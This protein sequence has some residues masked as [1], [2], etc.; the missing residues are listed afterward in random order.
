MTSNSKK[1]TVYLSLIIPAYNEE[2]RIAKS[3][4]QILQYL[5][6]Q[7]YAS[8]VVIVND[9]SVD[10]TVEEVHGIYQGRDRVRILQNGKNLGKGGA[11]S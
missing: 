2:K 11:I 6:T 3:L 7:P 10:R 8:E 1:D 4:K 5:E 9:G